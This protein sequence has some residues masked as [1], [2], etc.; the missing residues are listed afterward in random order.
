M[1]ALATALLSIGLVACERSDTDVT[2]LT[3]ET[4]ADVIV[5][6]REAEREALETD[7]AVQVYARRKA[8][9]LERHGTSEQ[10]LRRFVELSSRDL[11][12]LDELWED[13]SQRLRRPMDA[14]E[15]S[16]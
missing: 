1:R 7:S 10:E 5:E 9:I 3:P 16:T 6:L 13:I 11:P 15:D 2:A 12:L 4:F 14:P 8:E